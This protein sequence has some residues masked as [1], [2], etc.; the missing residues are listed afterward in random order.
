MEHFPSASMIHLTFKPLLVASQKIVFQA[1]YMVPCR[2]RSARI[3]AMRKTMHLQP[4]YD[5]R[6]VYTAQEVRARGFAPEWI[7]R[8]Y[9]EDR[10]GQ[11]AQR[12]LLKA[13]DY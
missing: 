12:Y 2:S 8:N 3:P 4:V 10:L 13:S 7:I 6:R 1:G 9:Q 5:C 11:A